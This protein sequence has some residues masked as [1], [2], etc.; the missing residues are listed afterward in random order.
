MSGEVE[1]VLPT[2]ITY[3]KIELETDN[4]VTDVSS[5]G[6][7]SSK[8][9]DSLFTI[10][11][12]DSFTGLSA[13]EKL[14]LSYTMT[15]SGEKQPKIVKL[16]MNGLECF[17]GKP[18]TSLIFLMFSSEVTTL[19]VYNLIFSSR[20]S[21]STASSTNLARSRSSDVF[22]RVHFRKQDHFQ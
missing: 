20:S 1:I 5:V 13:G 14:E 15:F 22:L 21:R 10:I 7:G 18:S 16:T 19:V 11:N 17:L 3:Y 9:S 12:E 6:A 8:T 4:P 2:D